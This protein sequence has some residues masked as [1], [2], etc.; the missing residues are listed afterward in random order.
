MKANNVSRFCLQNGI[1]IPTVLLLIYFFLMKQLSLALPPEETILLA[2]EFP[3]RMREFKCEG[4]FFEL[5][6]L[7]KHMTKFHDEGDASFFPNVDRLLI[8]KARSA[9][10]AHEKA[11][12]FDDLFLN[13]LRLYSSLSEVGSGFERTRWCAIA[14]FQLTRK[15]GDE[16]FLIEGNY[17]VAIS[18]QG[19]IVLPKLSEVRPSNPHP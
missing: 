11:I 2:G 5:W 14:S 16:I 18:L 3:N 12:N 6:I 8:E 10:L 19:T 4:H 15:A 9:V 7:E 17:L 1:F 13:E